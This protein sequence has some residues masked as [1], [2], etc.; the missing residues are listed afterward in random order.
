MITC[1]SSGKWNVEAQ[2][3]CTGIMVTSKNILF[4]M[5]VTKQFII[6]FNLSFSGFSYKSFIYNKPLQT[7]QSCRKCFSVGNKQTNNHSNKRTNKQTI[8]IKKQMH[9]YTRT[10]TFMIFKTCFIW[11]LTRYYLNI[12]LLYYIM[13]IC[14]QTSH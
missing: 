4:K 11:N 14:L 3:H 7:K 12:Q 9:V 5:N 10:W 1:L 8:Q 2:P 13:Q 6:L